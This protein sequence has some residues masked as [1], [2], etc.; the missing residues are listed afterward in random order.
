[1]PLLL[2][3]RS[4]FL[5][6]FF[7]FIAHSPLPAGTEAGGHGPTFDNGLPLSDL[8]TRL[9]PLYPSTAPPFLLAAGGLS[10]S[11][12][13]STALAL[14]AAAVVPGTALCAASESLLPQSQKE[15]LVLTDSAAKTA[16]GIKWDIARDGANHWPEGV[17]G[18]AVSN[19]TSQEEEGDAKKAHERYQ[20][21]V[22]EKDIERVVTWAGA[23]SFHL[24]LL[25]K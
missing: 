23:F 7:P 25:R 10:S 9:S 8:L 11:S 5:T 2:K 16:R 14:G 6:A 1:M 21:A 22:K 24:T 13:I 12:T 20:V 17:D 19:L 15:H 18:R 4:S 3:V